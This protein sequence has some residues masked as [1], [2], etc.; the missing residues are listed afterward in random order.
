MT[1]DNIRSKKLPWSANLG[2]A[3]VAVAVAAAIVLGSGIGNW[4]LVVVVGARALPGRAASRGDRVEG[5]RAARNRMWQTLIYSPACWRSCR[6]PRWS[7]RWSPRARPAG[8]RLLQH[9]DEQHRR[10]GPERGRLPRDHRH[11]EQVG[12]ATL[13]AV[14]LGVLGAIYLVEY[15]RGKFAYTV[16]FFVDVMTGHPVDR[17]RAVHPRRSGC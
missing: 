7:G 13:M 5:R 14:P 2:V 8:R 4:V 11:A 6:W 12:I 16:R 10:P 15:G 9:V 3:V 1:P 17:G